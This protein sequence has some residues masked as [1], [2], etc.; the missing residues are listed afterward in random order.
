M[1]FFINTYIFILKQINM[2]TKEFDINW[3][4][5]KNLAYKLY[6]SYKVDSNHRDDLL[7]VARIGMVKGLETY[8]EGLG[9]T[10]ITWV[11]LHMQKEQIDYLNKN[12]RTIRLPQNVIYSKEETLP[13][14]IVTSLDKPIYDDS[15]EPLYSTIAYDEEE[16]NTYDVNTDVLRHYISQLKERYQIIL[17]MYYTEEKTVTEIGEKLDIS[18]QA[19]SEQLEKA[20]LKLRQLMNVIPKVD[21]LKGVRQNNFGP[22]KN[23]GPKNKGT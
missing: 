5:Y 9:S 14:E 8:K 23:K 11:R 6:L 7:Q 1:Y 4:K 2:T 19:V 12:I 15:N 21:K 22:N 10:E 13:T 20:I 3:N 17:K 16:E 18:R